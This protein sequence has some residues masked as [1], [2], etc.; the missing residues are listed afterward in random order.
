[1]LLQMLHDLCQHSN[2][3]CMCDL[4][5][6]DELSVPVIPMAKELFVQTLDNL[7]LTKLFFLCLMQGIAMWHKYKAGPIMLS[8]IYTLLLI[9]R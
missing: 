9:R 8:N 6:R 7:N 4:Q 3:I 2:S 5:R 1:M